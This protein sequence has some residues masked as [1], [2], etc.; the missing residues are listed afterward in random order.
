MHQV[1]IQP[2]MPAVPEDAAEFARLHA[3]IKPRPE[4]LLWTQIPWE[5][6]LWAARMRAREAGKPI[7]MWAM[8]GNPLGC[9]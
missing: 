4:E 7:F 6:D 3:A 1:E 5:T 9:V 2:D 8:N